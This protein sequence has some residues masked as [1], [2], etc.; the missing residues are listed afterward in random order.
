MR[1]YS[2]SSQMCALA[3]LLDKLDDASLEKLRAAVALCE[4]EVYEYDL[5]YINETMGW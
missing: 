2:S 5:K 3:Q 1:A 4:P